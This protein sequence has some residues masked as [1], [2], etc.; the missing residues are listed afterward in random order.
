MTSYSDEIIPVSQNPKIFYMADDS[1][2]EQE[3]EFVG[4]TTRYLIV[5]HPPSSPN[6]GEDW[7]M[8]RN[9]VNH[10]LAQG[11]LRIEGEIPELALIE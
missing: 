11:R 8:G 1:S 3:M 7:R 6:A 5:K 9:L 4:W 10:Y 2:P